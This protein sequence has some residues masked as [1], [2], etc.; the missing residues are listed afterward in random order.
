M[1]PDSRMPFLTQALPVSVSY[2]LER[3]ASP[4]REDMV[5]EVQN[6]W[7]WGLILPFSAHTEDR[8]CHVCYTRNK[9]SQWEGSA[10]KSTPLLDLQFQAV[11]KPKLLAELQ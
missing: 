1:N 5:T 2:T 10:K 3:V 9:R 7:S 11:N 6:F 8:N 4:I